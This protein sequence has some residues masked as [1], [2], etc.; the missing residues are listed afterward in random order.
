MLLDKLQ[1]LRHRVLKEFKPC[2]EEGRTIE[3]GFLV[4]EIQDQIIE[5]NELDGGP[6]HPH[7]DKYL[8]FFK[9]IIVFGIFWIGVLSAIRVINDFISPKSSGK[10]LSFEQPERMRV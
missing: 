2:K 7:K 4:G 5:G 3:F 10:L 8:R 1:F 9:F 6:L